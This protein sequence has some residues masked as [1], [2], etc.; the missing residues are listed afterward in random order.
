[1]KRILYLTFYFEPD[2]CAGSFRNTPL[3]KTLAQQCEGEGII[4][5]LTTRPNRYASYA[6]TAPATE[7]IF[8]N[9]LVKRFS[10]PSHK[11]GMVDQVL[12]FASYAAQVIKATRR[13]KYDLVVASSS[14]LFTAWLGAQIAKK[15]GIPLYLDI[16]DLFVDTIQDVLKKAWYK[17]LLLR[18][19]KRIE[20]QTFKRASH[21][22]LISEGFRPYFKEQPSAGF[23]YFTNGVDDEIVDHP[24]NTSMVKDPSRIKI[25]YAG[26]IGEGQG[27]HCILP[28]VA[29]T[30]GQQVHI[31]VIGDGGARNLLDQKIKTLGLSNIEV[32]PPM[33]RAE[34][35]R[36]YDESDV[37]FIHLNDYPAF[38]KVL[39]S[40]VF[41]LAAWN[42]PILAGVSGYAKTFI[43]NE[44]QGA[45]V[46]HPC[47]HKGMIKY[48]EHIDWR[49][50]IDRSAFLNTYRRSTIN[51][52]MA[53][54]MMELM[55]K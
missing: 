38:L 46:F 51:E 18:W 47:D 19:L 25:V 32:I 50:Q 2:L 37:L 22:N 17:N 34:L 5:V 29:S 21:I 1:M 31:T 44:V 14:R 40:K 11:S 35:F 52:Q 23:T 41:E 15:Q 26:N 24:K 13:T 33:P 28:E 3:A 27:L 20:Q 6:V 55:I 12:G 48:L 45:Y 9:L 43:Q 16:R 7:A 30:M 4:E 42:K 49:T 53:G 36:Y 54:S 8:E 39:P 10:M